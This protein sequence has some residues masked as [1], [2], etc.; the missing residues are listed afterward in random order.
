MRRRSILLWE[1]YN[2][3]CRCQIWGKLESHEDWFIFCTLPL[4]EASF[5][6]PGH[7]P[8]CLRAECPAVGHFPLVQGQR[9]TP[10]NS[11][12]LLG[13]RQPMNLSSSW[14][15]CKSWFPLAPPS[16]AWICI[17][18]EIVVLLYFSFLSI[19]QSAVGEANCVPGLEERA[20][21]ALNRCTWGTEQPELVEQSLYDQLIKDPFCFL[22]GRA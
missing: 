21:F 5:P 14:C 8:Y 20:C 12:P 6:P 11:T 10:L 1:V 17:T 4:Q 7:W 15:L 3:F 19:S 18:E 22:K 16:I 9:A 2:G 13:L